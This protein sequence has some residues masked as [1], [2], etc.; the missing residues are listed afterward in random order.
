L[1][2]FYA[3]QVIIKIFFKIIRIPGPDDEADTAN[4]AKNQVLSK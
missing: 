1:R 3:D 4:E 2:I